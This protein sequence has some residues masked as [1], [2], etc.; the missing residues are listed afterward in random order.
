MYEIIRVALVK[1]VTFSSTFSRLVT[2][3]L[4]EKLGNMFLS[5]TVWCVL[6]TIWYLQYNCH[7]LV[8]HK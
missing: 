2:C 6:W 3:A 8:N 7:D 1:K 4:I 5:C